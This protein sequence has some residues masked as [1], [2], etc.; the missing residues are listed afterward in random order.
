MSHRQLWDKMREKQ[1][2]SKGN[3]RAVTT[4]VS[5]NSGICTYTYLYFTTK[6]H[7]IYEYVR[8]SGMLT[9][10]YGGYHLFILP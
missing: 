6:T 7:R 10:I 3:I 1:R 4:L 8:D 2:E 5:Q 9:M